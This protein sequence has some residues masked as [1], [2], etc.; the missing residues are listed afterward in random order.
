MIIGNNR[1]RRAVGFA[2]GSLLSMGGG[3]GGDPGGGDGTAFTYERDETGSGASGSAF[4]GKGNVV[5]PNRRLSITHLRAYMTSAV[6]GDF[7]LA[8]VDNTTGEIL[9]ILGTVADVVTTALGWTEVALPAAVTVHPD[10]SYLLLFDR[11]DSAGSTSS[12]IRFVSGWTV[13]ESRNVI[14]WR[15]NGAATIVGSVNDSSSDADWMIDWRGEYFDDPIPTIVDHDMVEIEDDTSD[16]FTFTYP[17]GIAAGDALLLILMDD[18]S[19]ENEFNYT[20]PAGYDQV[21]YF[22]NFSDSGVTIMVKE[23]T[24]SESGSLTVAL[25]SGDGRDKVGFLLVVRGASTADTII[26][27]PE[28]RSSSSNVVTA[29]DITTE[30][31]NSL[32]F[33]AISFDGADGGPMTNV[34]TDFSILDQGTAGPGSVGV[35]GVVVSRGL[36]VPGA[37]G[38]ASLNAAASDGYATITFSIAPSGT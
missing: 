24:G 4:S 25:A 30:V 10:A 8:R 38:A 15:N 32:V 17:A 18:D 29:L 12:T 20:E 16:D 21:A 26:V 37:S 14:G 3:G 2:N 36:A 34:N 7:M 11:T 6:T 9:E 27:G 1:L 28:Y 35:T 19:T 13:S 23:A 31:P 22:S 5:Q 33:S